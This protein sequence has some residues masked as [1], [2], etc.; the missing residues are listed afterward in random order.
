[1]TRITGGALPFLL[2]MM[3]QVGF[4]MSAAKSGLI[5]FAAAAGAILMKIASPPILRWF[6]FRKTLVW[7]GVIATTSIA[8]CAAFRPSWPMAA[9]YAVLLLGGFFQSLQFTAY[10]T[11][12]YADIPQARMSAATS[13]YATFQQLMLSMGICASSGA[14][15]LSIAFTGH[16][17]PGLF[18]FSVAFLAVTAIS[19]LASPVCAYLPDDAGNAMSGHGARNQ[20]V[21]SPDA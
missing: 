9:I 1:L 8:I 19:I 11:I 15:A 6:G 13:F 14:L 10:N 5:T 16:A 3:M 18:D 20:A 2:P 17:Q 12:A 4:G 7:N 21:L